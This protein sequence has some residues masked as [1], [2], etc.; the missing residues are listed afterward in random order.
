METSGFKELF[1]IANI[2]K[3]VQNIAQLLEG[4]QLQT[5]KHASQTGNI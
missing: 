4:V 1:L 5:Q 3:L 2:G